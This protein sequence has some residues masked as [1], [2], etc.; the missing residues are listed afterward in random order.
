MTRDEAVAELKGAGLFSY[1]I[2]EVLTK[3]PESR[4][5][6]F[7]GVRVERTPSQPRW[8]TQRSNKQLFTGVPA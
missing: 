7:Q 8:D 2:D 1:Q 6:D 3:I 5:K 4:W